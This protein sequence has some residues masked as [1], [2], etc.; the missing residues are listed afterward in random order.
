M[1]AFT[2]FFFF[3]SKSG[4]KGYSKLNH[5]EIEKLLYILLKQAAS[6]NMIV[7][8]KIFEHELQI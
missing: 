8:T 4:T 5:Y 3:F 1:N 2:I 6:F 7:N